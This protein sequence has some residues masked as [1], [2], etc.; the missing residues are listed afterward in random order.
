MIIEQK[1]NYENF[2]A[3]RHHG[4]YATSYFRLLKCFSCQIDVHISRKEKTTFMHQTTSGELKWYY[5]SE[6]TNFGRPYKRTKSWTLVQ[7][8]VLLNAIVC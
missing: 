3:H 5:F 4:K 1:K 2:K 8:F 7:E 6:K